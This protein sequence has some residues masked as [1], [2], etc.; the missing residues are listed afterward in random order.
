MLRVYSTAPLPLLDIVAC[1][2]LLFAQKEP[3]LLL[4]SR[5]V[6]KQ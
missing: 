2:V 4:R 1:G 5:T 6:P 3:L